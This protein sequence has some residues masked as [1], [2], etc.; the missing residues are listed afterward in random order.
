MHS[1]ER[2][3]K[4]LL[5]A[6]ARPRRT[7][8]NGAHVPLE[9]PAVNLDAWRHY[10]RA[11][12]YR[13]MRQPERAVAELR[14]AL[15][16]DPNF[17]RAIHWLAVL[18]AGRD[19]LEKALPLLE[20]TVRL[21][22][23]DAG[24]WYNL[25]FARDHGNDPARA[26]DAFRE[27][28]RLSPKLDQAWYG[29]GRCHATLGQL[30]EAVKAFEEA[31]RLQPMKGHAWYELGLVHHRRHEAERVREIAEHLNRYDRHA[32]RKLIRDTQRDDLAHLVSDLRT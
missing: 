10:L 21:R 18:L 19:E 9:Y 24:A 15:N 7:P 23:G 25:G 5:L 29:L 17:A 28:T 11:R 12:L 20:Q 31:A 27:A 14:A 30:D 6:L 13:L 4:P 3:L 26:I 8:H 16:H 1:R 32:A 2:P 22:P